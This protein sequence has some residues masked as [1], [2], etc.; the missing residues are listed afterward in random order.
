MGGSGVVSTG[1]AYS[2]EGA[3][4]TPTTEYRE[5]PLTCGLT[6]LVDAS[7]YEWLMKRCWQAKFGGG[8]RTVYA[9]RN[10]GGRKDRH[11][12]M[13]HREILGLGRYDKRQGD[14]I[15]GNTLDNRRSNLR[16]ATHAE[17]QHN[18]GKQKNGTSGYKGVNF[19]KGKGVYE[20][21][22]ML[23]KKKIYL[24]VRK[25][26]KEAYEELYVPA[27]RKYHGQFSRC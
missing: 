4:M 1:Q 3:N 9:G 26:A 25:T 2:L 5:I 19:V 21:K 8:R 20:A 17:N 11:R 16:I 27:S 24:G 14:H 10:E 12:V 13:M 22:I 23:D 18:K 6:A 15:N 7:D